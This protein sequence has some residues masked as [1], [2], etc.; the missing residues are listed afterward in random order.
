M[1]VLHVFGCNINQHKRFK[2]YESACKELRE[3]AQ[4]YINGGFQKE[5]TC[6]LEPASA[7]LTKHIFDDV[8]AKI[9]L[10]VYEDNDKD[11][12]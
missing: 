1:Y 3:V 4:Y 6:R 11:A 2:D 7:T 5:S 9:S 12:Y 8:Y 10:N